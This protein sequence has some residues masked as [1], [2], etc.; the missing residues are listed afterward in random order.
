MIEIAGGILLA[1]LILVFLSYIIAAAVY[2][3]G[4][5]L[6]IGA[7][8]LGVWF[9]SGLSREDWLVL[10]LLAA[11]FAAPICCAYVWKRRTRPTVESLGEATKRAP[12]GFEVHAASLCRKA[13]KT[14]RPP[15]RATG[16]ISTALLRRD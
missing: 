1:I 8:A 14:Y 13:S 9:V 11:I 3:G 12:D 4:A 15:R 6:L 7:L 10:A 5:A 2:I 16:L